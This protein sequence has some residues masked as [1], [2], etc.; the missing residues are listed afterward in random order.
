MTFWRTWFFIILHC[1]LWKGS[2]S[3][4][5]DEQF[6][7]TLIQIFV[8]PLITFTAVKLTY[9]EKTSVYSFTWFIE[10]SFNDAVDKLFQ[11]TLTTHML[12]GTFRFAIFTKFRVWIQWLQWKTWLFIILHSLLWEGSFS[13]AVDEQLQPTLIQIIVFFHLLHLELWKLLIWK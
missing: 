12:S 5:I 1:L 6:Q 10:R 9:L 13:D 11:H 4:A 3:D 7:P 8:N 2:F